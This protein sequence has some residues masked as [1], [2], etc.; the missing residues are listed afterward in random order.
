MSH[1]LVPP[2]VPEK[3]SQIQTSLKKFPRNAP[4]SIVL[5]C[6]IHTLNAQEIVTEDSERWS[7]DNTDNLYALRKFA[8]S[9]LITAIKDC[10]RSAIPA[11][12][13]LS[14][15]LQMF[16]TVRNDLY[17]LIKLQV[18]NEVNF[19]LYLWLSKDMDELY[20]NGSH[21]V[22]YEHLA[23]LVGNLS[24]IAKE[25]YCR[26]S[27]R[28][29]IKKDIEDILLGCVAAL[30]PSTYY[31]ETTCENIKQAREQSFVF[32][33]Y[34]RRLAL[35]SHDANFIESNV[36]MNIYEM[37][38]L[39][40]SNH[41]AFPNQLCF[42]LQTLLEIIIDWWHAHADAIE[43]ILIEQLGVTY[44]WGK[45]V[46]NLEERI[47]HTSKDLWNMKK[48][49]EALSMIVLEHVPIVEAIGDHQW[50]YGSYTGRL[51]WDE[52][53]RW[54]HVD[55]A[56]QA[57]D[58]DYMKYILDKVK[59]HKTFFRYKFTKY[60]MIEAEC[61]RFIENLCASL[62]AHRKSADTGRRQR[63]DE[64]IMLEKAIK[65]YEKNLHARNSMIITDYPVAEQQKKLTIL[66]SH[67]DKLLGYKNL[68]DK[69]LHG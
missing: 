41:H 11:W 60:G 27:I 49:W 54:D 51:S 59:K 35:Y 18:E 24:D 17:R 33:E 26:K 66:L 40:F 30:C 52:W 36:C 14:A 61:A 65:K 67:K 12:I 48:L 7:G 5:R 58:T 23:D 29:D 69:I 2:V 28:A 19:S 21:K 6:L 34:V 45:F 39:A 20:H 16:L 46:L 25:N 42:I 50:F 43:A 56:W 37:F 3:I 53:C 44:I 63:T 31:M 32:E 8:V 1:S 4:T 15:L 22:D 55:D 64:Y 13:D 10:D 68:R 38:S 57:W 62:Q 47:P 9:D